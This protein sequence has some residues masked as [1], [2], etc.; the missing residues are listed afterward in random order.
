[1]SKFLLFLLNWVILCPF[2]LGQQPEIGICIPTVRADSA[3][4]EFNN[5]IDGKDC[6]GFK[7][8]RDV[9]QK[10]LPSVIKI[11]IADTRSPYFGI[12][13]VSMVEKNP[14]VIKVT[15]TFLLYDVENQKELFRE[16]FYGYAACQPARENLEVAKEA[17]NAS[18]LL[19][20][21]KVAFEL[22][23]ALPALGEPAIK[24]ELPRDAINAYLN[25]DQFCVGDSLTISF[26]PQAT[27][28]VYILNVTS[29]E[30]QMIFPLVGYLKND[31][32][33]NTKYTYPYQDKNFPFG[34]FIVGPIDER[35][36]LILS[37]DRIV[38][39][40]ELLSQ[41]TKE[42][43]KQQD[44]AITKKQKIKI[45]LLIPVPLKKLEEIGKWLSNHKWEYKELRAKVLQK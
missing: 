10:N 7:K 33:A 44:Q 31:V 38:P 15:L 19:A 4:P 24:F 9:F 2:L 14:A 11:K 17:F 5:A 18:V 35:Y 40:D 41:A 27:G 43:K 3:W 12:A 23:Y 6:W 13:K 42:A 22:Q 30:I 20:C 26:E 37:T 32:I 25:K 8:L 39:L 1:M 29:K 28:F 34:T 36:I 16:N 45:N 21:Q